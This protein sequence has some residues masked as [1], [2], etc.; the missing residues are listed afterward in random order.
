MHDIT[1]K[2]HLEESLKHAE[3]KHAELL[4]SQAENKYETLYQNMPVGVIYQG[5]DGKVLE[6]NPAAERILGVG[7]AQFSDL[8]SIHEKFKTIHG[9]GSDF[10]SEEHQPR[11]H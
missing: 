1:E 11:F 9:D 10:P 6:F 7:L 8:A 3:R 5:V 4:L 2:K